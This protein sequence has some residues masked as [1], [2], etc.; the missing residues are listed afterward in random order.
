MA[1][2]L[3]AKYGSNNQALTLTIA[4]LANDAA[5]GSTAVDNTSNLFLDVLFRLK[6]KTAAASTSA[7]GYV[8][9]Y[10][11]ASVDGGTTYDYAFGGSDAA[12]TLTEPPNIKQLGSVSCIANATTYY[13][14]LLSV[15][16]AF[17]GVVPAFWGIVI[18]N[19]TG[20]TLD[21]TGGNH[22]AIWQGV[23][24]QYS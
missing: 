16:A 19:K 21:S 20:A 3:K 11:Y 7:T 22:S 9:I 10:A 15:A 14:P 18:V 1:G 5:R 13:S 2:D 12:I 8:L 23:Y 17:G 24:A 6:V 4:S